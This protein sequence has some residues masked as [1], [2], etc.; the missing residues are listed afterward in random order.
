MIPRIIHYCWFGRGPMPDLAL[1]CIESWHQCMPD[2]EY[3]LWNEDNFDIHCNPYVEEAYHARKFAFVS[4]FARLYALYTEG[5]IYMDTDVEVF[6]SYESLMH[7]TGFIGFEGTKHCPVGTGTIASI[8]KG[9]WLEEQIAAYNDIHFIRPDGSFDLTTN[10]VRISAIMRKNG[11]RQDGTEQVYKDMH[12]FP[13]DF[14]CPRQT[15]GEYFKTD[16]TYCD[17]HYM[18]T[19]GNKKESLLLRAL[20]KKNLTRL[21]KLKRKL[22]G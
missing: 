8:P 16:N 3:R 9:K 5:G 2:F 1:R 11:F 15:T 18:G 19:W 22:L 21:I 12:V 17:H 6:K 7:L 20:G 14:F 4:D 10:P 13:V